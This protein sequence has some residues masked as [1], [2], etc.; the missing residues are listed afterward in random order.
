MSF[1]LPSP[2]RLAISPWNSLSVCESFHKFKAESVLVRAVQTET[3]LRRTATLI[4]EALATFFQIKTNPEAF[5]QQ[6]GVEALLKVAATYSE[7]VDLHGHFMG[8]LSVMTNVLALRPALAKAEVMDFGVSSLK[9][10][11]EV[12]E[13]VL[14]SAP[15]LSVCVENEE[16]ATSHYEDFFNA[17][18]N[19]LLVFEESRGCRCDAERPLA[20]GEGVPVV[21]QDHEYYLKDNA[22]EAAVLF[23]Q[24][25][26]NDKQVV[27]GCCGL[28][29]H[30]EVL[31]DDTQMNVLTTVLTVFATY[32]KDAPINLA[33]AKLL[34]TLCLSENATSKMLHLEVYNALI[35]SMA[36]FGGSEEHVEAVLR[37]LIAMVRGM[38]IPATFVNM[39]N[40]R[41]LYRTAT[42]YSKDAFIL[43]LMA[44]LL[45]LL[46]PV[47]ASD[48]VTTGFVSILLLGVRSSG[49]RPCIIACCHALAA[50]AISPE[51]LYILSQQCCSSDMLTLLKT[52]SKDAEVTAAALYLLRAMCKSS[53]A[54]RDMDNANFVL[55]LW[56]VLKRFLEEER[57]VALCGLVLEALARAHESSLKQ[58]LSCFDK[59][60]YC[61]IVEKHSESEEAMAGLLSLMTLHIASMKKQPLLPEVNLVDL[62]VQTL[63]RFP[64]G[65]G[66]CAACYELME[67]CLEELKEKKL[68]DASESLFVAVERSIR[69]CVEVALASNKTSAQDE[70]RRS[71]GG[72]ANEQSASVLVADAAVARRARRAT[73]WCTHREGT[74]GVP[75]A[76]GDPAAGDAGSQRDDQVPVH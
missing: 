47:S 5:V 44:N 66:S 24:N 55:E 54:L 49:D 2:R 76:E 25:F 9:L 38:E 67:I 29:N 60:V 4:S 45:E 1:S 62:T 35:K 18:V 15:L 12:E 50:L 56:E 65:V 22:A 59:Q 41:I 16:W 3:S 34:L 70:L 63:E 19:A 30:C 28:L 51:C 43:T 42:D 32:S 68:L 33:C 52:Y 37:A 57:V 69:N 7:D 39:E 74:S 36:T 21:S 48:L 71:C 11:S 73:S 46:A 72:A 40:L 75:R 31:A 10:C 8:C 64:D 58:L 20:D 26:M 53:D 23:I 13:Y 61:S 27:Q 14:N 6:G 17:V